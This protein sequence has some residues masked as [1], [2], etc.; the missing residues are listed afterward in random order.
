MEYTKS[1]DRFEELSKEELQE[2]GIDFSAETIDK[3]AIHNLIKKYTELPIAYSSSD[4]TLFIDGEA[5]HLIDTMNIDTIN[6]KLY[7]DVVYI[8]EKY[9]EELN[10]MFTLENATF[11]EEMYSNQDAYA[12]SRNIKGVTFIGEKAIR[13]SNSYKALYSTLIYSFDSIGEFKRSIHK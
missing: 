9:I 7:L 6:N 11:V 5:A 1:Q 4:Y 2:L 10:K 12:I 13:T 8:S 3:D